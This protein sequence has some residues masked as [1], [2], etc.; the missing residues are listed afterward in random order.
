MRLSHSI[1]SIKL[2]K[3]HHDPSP[4]IKSDAKTNVQNVRLISKSGVDSLT[5]QYKS[6]VHLGAKR[7]PFRKNEWSDERDVKQESIRFLLLFPQLTVNQGSA[8]RDSTT[9]LSLGFANYSKSWRSTGRDKQEELNSSNL[10]DT[11]DLTFI[12]KLFMLRISCTQSSNSGSTSFS[13]AATD[14]PTDALAS[15]FFDTQLNN[16][17]CFCMDSTPGPIS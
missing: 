17:R 7:R 12:C 1:E 6:P 9:A 8:A 3:L 14:K 15:L 10:N 5:I 11:R 4:L 16:M 13:S 2:L